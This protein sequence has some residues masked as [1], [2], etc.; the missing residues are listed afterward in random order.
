MQMMRETGA[1][2]ER[3]RQ[4]AHTRMKMRWKKQCDPR[5]HQDPCSHN[6]HHVQVRVCILCAYL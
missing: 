6:T 4:T 5:K 3:D 2:V 1:K